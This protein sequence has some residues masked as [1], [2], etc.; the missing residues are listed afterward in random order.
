M[1]KKSSF[2][3]LVGA[4]GGQACSGLLGDAGHLL[5]KKVAGEAVTLS[6]EAPSPR[7]RRNTTTIAAECRAQGPQRGSRAD[8]AGTTYEL[9]YRPAY[10]ADQRDKAVE[11]RRSSTQDLRSR[12]DNLSQS[13]FELRGKVADLDAEHEAAAENAGPW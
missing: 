13:I 2:R 8:L 1:P 5:Q 9:D 3:S 4:D 7:C 12:S 10:V 6:S 11:D